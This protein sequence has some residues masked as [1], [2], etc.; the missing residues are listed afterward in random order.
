MKKLTELFFAFAMTV[1]LFGLT[2]CNEFSGG[3][4]EQDDSLTTNLKIEGL[5][6]SFDG[7]RTL[8]PASFERDNLYYRLTGTMTGSGK[9]L[10]DGTNNYID[11]EADANGTA[12]VNI[13]PAQWNLTLTAYSDDG[14]TTEVLSGKQY[15]DLS[16]GGDTIKFTLFPSGNE[17]GI[18]IFGKDATE[19]KFEV[20]F[21]AGTTK[22]A[23]YSIGLYDKDTDI[24]IPD[25]TED[26][27][28]DASTGTIFK[29]W[30]GIPQGEYN[31]KVI[32][33]NADNKIINR[34]DEL[35]IVAGGTT[36]E[37][38]KDLEIENFLTS[39]TAPENLVAELAAAPVTDHKTNEE[40][41]NAVFTWDDNSS[42][43]AGFALTLTEIA[44]DGTPVTGSIYT[45]TYTTADYNE[46]RF[47]GGTLSP[48]SKT[49]TI[50]LPTGHLFAAS[51]KAVNEA[52]D[53]DEVYATSTNFTKSVTVNTENT[54]AIGRFQVSYF[55]DGGTLTTDEGT[56]TG[57]YYE[58]A[59]YGTDITILELKEFG[60]DTTSDT[61]EKP[62]AYRANDS[63][64]TTKIV[65]LKTGTTE[66]KANAENENLKHS[67]IE[68]LELKLSFETGIEITIYEFKDISKERIKLEF[69]EDGTTFAEATAPIKINGTLKITLDGTDTSAATP[70][71]YAD[72]KSISKFEVSYYKTTST[73]TK[74]TSE[75]VLTDNAGTKTGETTI[76]ISTIDD[77]TY[78]F[79]IRA[80]DEKSAKWY[81]ETI[82]TTI[83]RKS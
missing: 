32:F 63:K 30:D 35:V 33:Y 70:D 4:V 10:S 42:N 72:N 50:S 75:I 55:L 14:R 62:Y 23:G 2:A 71:T 53:S 39:P 24:A 37:R 76:D 41:Y 51:I 54:A 20:S 56:Y 12:Y 18:V 82:Y 28:V 69:S 80:Y 44:T 78:A 3:Y 58:H 8:D 38:Y 22:V 66:Y 77:G 5:N 47:T 43:E 49:A 11:F 48:N 31:L 81:D 15:I 36:S 29:K 21:N 65:D 6:G 1:T 16:N 40:N 60:G 74:K 9:A 46:I 7:S 67:G 34:Y 83:S 59:T 13:A 73:G 57:T 68:N 45:K 25:T 27:N 64:T 19:G 17:D 52:G 79:Q 26:V 61:Q